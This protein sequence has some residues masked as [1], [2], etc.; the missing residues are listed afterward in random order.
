MSRPVFFRKQDLLWLLLPVLCISIL[1]FRGKSEVSVSAEVSINGTV[2]G[3]YPLQEPRTLSFPEADGVE[4]EIADGCI[5][6]IE[7]DCP[8]KRCVRMGSASQAGEMIVCLPHALII[9]LV[10][11]TDG[12]DVV[13]G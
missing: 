13:I 4:I 5:R 1:F 11:D 10:G 6:I 2:I 3:T 12:A 7:S 9:T 8:D